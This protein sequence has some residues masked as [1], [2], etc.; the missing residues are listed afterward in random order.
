MFDSLTDD[1]IAQVGCL[2]AFLGAIVITTLS[3]WLGSAR[4]QADRRIAGSIHALNPASDAVRTA[5]AQAPRR[6]AA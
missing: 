6:R 2:G 4:T 1:Q 3:Y 5:I